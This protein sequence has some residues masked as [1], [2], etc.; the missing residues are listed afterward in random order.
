MPA[1]PEVSGREPGL[2]VRVDTDSPGWPSL[3]LMGPY[4]VS[5]NPQFPGFSCDPSHH[6]CLGGLK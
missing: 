2:G 1:Q 3:H 4:D 5:G 6:V